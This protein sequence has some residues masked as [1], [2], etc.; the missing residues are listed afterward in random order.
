MPIMRNM[1][2]KHKLV[3]IIMLTCVVALL[4]AGAVFVFSEWASVRRSMVRNMTTHAAMTGD[5][6]KAA[7]AFEDANDA[8]QTLSVLEEES[9]IVYGC[10]RDKDGNVFADYN[11]DAKSDLI[12]ESDCRAPIC[13][14][15][16]DGY[17][18]ENGCL[19]VFKQIILDD[20]T[21]GTIC[22]RSD[23]QPMHSML[24]AKI[25][26]I[27]AVVLLASLAAYV[28]SS[29]LQRI[30]SGP[31]L[32]L[33]EV[34]KVVSQQK[35]Y[36]ARA[37]KESNDE[38]GLLIESF[39]EMLGQIQ[40]RD[41]AL[42]EAN[43]SLEARVKERTMELITANRDL[44]NSVERANLMAREAQAASESKGQFL[45][46]MSHEIR[47]PMNGILGFADI[48]ADEE[49]AK[50]HKE[51]VTIIRDCGRELLVLI[52]DILDFSKIEANK[53]AT[54]ITKCSLAEMLNSI[55]SFMRP[56][57]VE[58]ALE[59][60]VVES[61]GLPGEI[62]TDPVR[63]RQCL[64]NLVGNAIKFTE[65][66]HI[67]I[68]ASIHEE[69][70]EPH[71]Q[72]DVEDTGIG[73]PKD[74][75]GAVFEVFTQADGSHTRK[76]G[77][78]GLGLAITK[79][80]AEI[81]GGRL[82]VTSIEGEGSTFSLVLPVGVDASTDGFLDRHNLA[83]ELRTD[84]PEST[85]TLFSGRVLVAED[86]LTNRAL[87]E[88]LLKR[89]GLEVTIAMDGNE[90]VRMVQN[91]AFDLILMDMQMPNLNG[92]EATKT[93]RRQGIKTPIVAL[94]ANV[95]KG[96]D[97][98]CLAAGCDDYISKPID[99]ARLIEVIGKHLP[100]TKEAVCQDSST[101]A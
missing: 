42:V 71:I 50:Q 58:K 68:N 14:L 9:S 77:G 61:P 54:E 97:E 4:L 72:F 23:L 39:N 29:R 70:G 95:M 74:K 75:Q 15:G 88:L 89:M 10:V 46:N 41:S 36:S 17:S 19:T 52:N 93:L 49:L 73:I 18:F 59:L 78:S 87:I 7:L 31:I 26:T 76:Y 47:T 86:S 13:E 28:V 27:I 37:A 6:C 34:A 100:A 90:A 44:H 79:R 20:E 3:S 91:E 57:A 64:V 1:A 8:E 63:L 32:N 83:E 33:A 12:E 84:Q 60:R 55:E 45:A 92:Y 48:L 85:Q 101:E 80:L 21:I 16:T 2:I 5:N 22:L 69:N 66:G 35:D 62:S 94:T 11:R 43:E 99:R 40:Q 98:I 56:K 96:D 38:V 53:L 81:L 25:V 82:T 51:Y 65:V 30:I 24:R 67:N